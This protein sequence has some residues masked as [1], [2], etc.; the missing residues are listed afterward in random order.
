MSVNATECH[1]IPINTNS[2]SFF[3]TLLV[4]VVSWFVYVYLSEI[5]K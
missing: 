4:T 2:S 1:E 5:Y 3:I